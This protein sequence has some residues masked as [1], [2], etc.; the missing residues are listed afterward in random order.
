LLC[1]LCAYVC[2]DGFIF[3]NEF[4]IFAF[5][6]YHQRLWTWQY[7]FCIILIMYQYCSLCKWLYHF[8]W[9]LGQWYAYVYS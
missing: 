7:Y 8:L 9:D 5:S 3:C 4:C 6:I 1:V 2:V